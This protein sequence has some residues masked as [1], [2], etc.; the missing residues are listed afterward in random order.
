MLIQYELRRLFYLMNIHMRRNSTPKALIL[1]A[2]FNDYAVKSR[3][4]FLIFFFQWATAKVKV[5]V[6]PRIS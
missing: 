3:K 4:I 6:Y 1:G 2:F 5:P